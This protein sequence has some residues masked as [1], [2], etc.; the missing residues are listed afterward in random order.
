MAAIAVACIFHFGSLRFQNALPLEEF[1][2]VQW[3]YQHGVL[4]VEFFWVISGFT[5]FLVYT[6]RID[7]GMSFEKYAARR[8]IRIFPLMIA[9][10]LITAVGSMIW[11]LTHEKTFWWGSDS[12][13]TLVLGFLGLTGFY[14]GW[15]GWNGPAWSLSVFFVCWIIFYIVIFFTRKDPA[16]RKTK[17]MIACL[18]IVLTGVGIQLSGSTETNP[19]FSTDMSRGYISFFS[20][21][22]L[23][24]LNQM[25]SPKNV[26]RNVILS[27][28]FLLMLAGIRI[29]GVEV[30]NY[31]VLFGAVIYPLLVFIVLNVK[32]ISKCLSIRPLTYLGK[33][34]YSV[35][36]CNCPIQ[37]YFS[38]INEGLG[39]P[40]SGYSVGLLLFFFVVHILV[41]SLFY[42][43]FEE[44]IPRKLK[45]RF[46]I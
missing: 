46:N 17:R 29:S 21:G 14:P 32:S 3:I 36:L 30:G 1:Y 23:Y 18:V 26:R 38:I 22:M 16:T 8:A 43:V 40:V 35:Y 44:K 41:G 37:I 2:P 10:L 11:F 45:K 5:T 34:S 12:L 20:G 31:S 4:L 7:E 39:S 24:Y 13:V 19:L 6:N 27:I 33:I 28:L 25:Q 42:L 15:S 9:T